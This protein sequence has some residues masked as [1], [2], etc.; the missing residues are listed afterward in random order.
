MSDRLAT[1]N[2]YP[3]I[4]NVLQTADVAEA[5]RLLIKDATDGK[6]FD[7]GK[8][9]VP[10]EKSALVRLIEESN[11][12]ALATDVYAAVENTRMNPALKT[13]LRETA[14]IPLTEKMI[15]SRNTDEPA[16]TSLKQDPLSTASFERELRGET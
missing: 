10:G 2:Q 16:T 13:I 11:N 7:E 4:K 6:L 5:A 14:N 1:I 9:L 12:A 8:S 15:V 3:R